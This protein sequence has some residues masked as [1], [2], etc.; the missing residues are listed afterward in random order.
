MFKSSSSINLCA[1]KS[2][3]F[4]SSICVTSTV[5]SQ[6]LTNTFLSTVVLS[7]VILSIRNSFP[8]LCLLNFTVP[9]SFSTFIDVNILSSF[10][11]Q[12]VK[13][14]AAP[15][16]SHFPTT[17]QQDVLRWS[18]LTKGHALAS[19]W[20]SLSPVNKTESLRMSEASYYDYSQTDTER[21]RDRKSRTK[22]CSFQST[23][24]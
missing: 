21:K 10:I 1:L 2:S 8:W 19:E 13:I 15:L 14:S 24:R 3:H 4:L 7:M 20:G 9:L 5:L 23:N 16:C 6:P 18:F 17:S 22:I 12:S 11:C